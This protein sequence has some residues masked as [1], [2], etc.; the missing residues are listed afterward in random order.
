MFDLLFIL[1]IL[2][3][4]CVIG[5]TIE[6]KHYQS[7][8]AREDQFLNLP[9]VNGKKFIEKD[10]QIQ[11][12]QLVTGSVVVSI[13]YFKMF[14]AGLRN[15]VGGRVVSYESLIDRA[16]REAILRMKQKAVG[17]DILLNMRVETSAVGQDASQKQGLGSSEVLAYATAV[18][19]KK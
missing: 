13:D 3:G 2:S 18:Y 8:K 10:K 7:I 15:I 11:N 12:A 17:A 1:V 16:R 14:L 19:Y 6:D 5:M 9:V 4:A